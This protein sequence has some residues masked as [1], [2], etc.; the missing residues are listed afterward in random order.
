MRSESRCWP[1]PQ[2]PED[3]PWAGG[4]AS[5]RTQMAAKPVL[6]VGKRPQVLAMGPSPQGGW[7]V[8]TIWPFVVLR[9]SDPGE[10][11]GGSCSV[12]SNLVL[13]MTHCHFYIFPI[14]T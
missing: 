12:F 2:A 9:A 8:L 6:A 5:E 3:L 10:S 7:R 1:G 4:P 13:E 11:T 14:V